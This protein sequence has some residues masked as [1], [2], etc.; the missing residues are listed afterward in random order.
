MM[1]V[2]FGYDYT[3]EEK[4]LAFR[5]FYVD[6]RL[7]KVKVSVRHGK[8]LIIE[9]GNTADEAIEKAKHTIKYPQLR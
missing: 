3:H 7:G 8:R 9:Y 1:N 4:G 2:P 6:H 5:V